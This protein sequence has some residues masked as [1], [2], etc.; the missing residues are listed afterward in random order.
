MISNARRATQSRIPPI[1]FPSRGRR[2][3]YFLFPTT[4]RDPNR[5]RSSG[6]RMPNLYA[7]IAFS[8]DPKIHSLSNPYFTGHIENVSD[9][10][11]TAKP[12]IDRHVRRP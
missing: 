11:A 6:S 10:G 5:D 4:E 9:S 8:Q 7:R 3:R 12:D 1:T 2:E